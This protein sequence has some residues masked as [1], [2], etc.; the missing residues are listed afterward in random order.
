[1][2]PEGGAPDQNAWFGLV[3]PPALGLLAPMV[4]LAETRKF[5]ITPQVGLVL[6]VGLLGARRPLAVSPPLEVRPSS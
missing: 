4:V 5:S 6:A 2:R 3:Q 1:V